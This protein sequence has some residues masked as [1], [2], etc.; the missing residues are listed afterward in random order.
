[1][2]L[3]TYIYTNFFLIHIPN[4]AP[5]W[6][7]LAEF[8]PQFSC[9]LRLWEGASPQ[10]SQ[11]PGASSLYKIRH[12]LPHWGQT[13]H[14]HATYVSGASDP[15]VDGLWLVSV[16]GSSQGF[17]LTLLVFLWG[18]Q[19]LQFLQSFQE[20]LLR[21]PEPVSRSLGDFLM[22]ERKYAK[23][24]WDYYRSSLCF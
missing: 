11:H 9:L 21:G 6:S 16:S 13:R 14:P 2:K 15:P 18:F 24:I 8:L 1:M 4:V 10:I 23:V 5:S 3:E 22:A 20:F 12:I 17:R 7:A 19:A